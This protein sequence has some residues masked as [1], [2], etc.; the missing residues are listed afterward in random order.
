V[1]T[2]SAQR[3][4]AADGPSL[5][6]NRTLQEPSQVVP[7][8][9]PSSV[10]VTLTHS[11]SQAIQAGNSVAC[12][13]DG[14]FTTTENGYLRTFTLEDFGVF[15]DF[16]VTEVSFGIE[17]LSAV[18]QTLTVNLFTLDAEPFI[19]DNMTL[20]G[21]ADTTLDPQALTLVT[22]PVTGTAPEGSTLV[23]EIDAPT[24]AGIGGFFIGSNNEGQTAPSY[25]R[26]ASCG[27]PEPTDTADVGAPGMHIVM[28]VTGTAEA[29][30][31]EV[32]EGT[33]WVDV[34]PL[35]GTV[36]PGGEQEVTVALYSTGLDPG[37]H[38]AVL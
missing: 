22:V 10:G 38:E 16:D 35:S 30:A 26:S 6:G 29:P 7:E 3:P 5:A 12:S 9:E 20:I 33:P 37:L 32:P 4:D 18:S 11:A 25:L 15:S 28:N 21:S 14:G 1:E 2:A 36:E 13:P 8:S 34:D 31:C 19:Y 23:V 17:S 27:L 24:V